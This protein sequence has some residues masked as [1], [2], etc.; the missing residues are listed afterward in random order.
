MDDEIER[1]ERI[2]SRRHLENKLKDVIDGEKL[3]RKTS[4]FREL[5][6]DQLSEFPQFT[7]IDLSKLGTPYQ[8]RHATS[9]YYD[10]AYNG[11]YVFY[12]SKESCDYDWDKYDINV[13][14]PLFVKA[15]VESR[16]SNSDK[17]ILY[18]LIDRDNE[19]ADCVCGACCQCQNGLR[20]T[21]HCVHVLSLIWYLSY[22]QF[23][24]PSQQSPWEFLKEHFP[25]SV[26]PAYET[27]DEEGD[28][29]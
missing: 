15:K 5:D 29:T 6:G 26:L 27:E 16:H 11:K 17:Y 21:Q 20:M 18:V 23:V 19:G 4:N 3:N 24:T 13:K 12:V 14:N 28:N 22:G 9:Y 10:H 8:L 1:A 2:L 7:L 25:V